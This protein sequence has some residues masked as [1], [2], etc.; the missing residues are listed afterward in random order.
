[1]INKILLDLK[2]KESEI[3]E[4]LVKW[5]DPYKDSEPC[6]IEFVVE[7][8]LEKPIISI[9]YP[10]KKLVKLESK[11]KNGI[12]Y[13]NLLDFVVI[14]YN[15]ESEEISGFTFEN[16]LQD[17]E[18]NKK[19]D[20]KFW[21]IL[22]EIYHNNKLSE[23]PPKLNG[24]DSLLFLLALKWIWIQEDL[25]YKLSSTE[26]NSV[27]KYKLLS[28]KGKPMSKGAGRA[29]FFGALVLLKNGF[30]ISEVKKI[31]PMYA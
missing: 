26:V 12:R 1:M 3:Y 22:S 25:N 8:T 15:S 27:T 7:G 29:K 31:I 16:I 24:I 21:K 23:E 11:R 4:E 19:N 9:R 5:F 30:S 14:I 10:G 13:G 6:S 28:R 17:F 2:G 20:D 18:A